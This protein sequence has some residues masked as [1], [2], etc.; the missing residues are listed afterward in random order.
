[1]N[2]LPHVHTYGSALFRK[3]GNFISTSLNQCHVPLW[4]RN[5]EHVSVKTV[6]LEFLLTRFRS[7][8]YSSRKSSSS[9]KK[10]SRTKKVDPEQSKVMKNEKDAFFVVRKGDV[11]GVFKSFADCQTQVGSSICDPPVSVYK[12][13]SLTK[14][15][16]IYLSSY[17]LKN[18]CYTIRAADVKE[19]IFGALMPCPFQ[20]AASSKGETSHNDATKKRPQDMLQLEYGV[21]LG[22]LGSIAVADLARK[23]A[24]LDPHAGAQITSSGHALV[25]LLV[26]LWQQS[27]TLEFDG[28]SKGNPG[29]AG[30]GA[31]LKTNA[32]NV[33]CKLREGL[34]IATNNAA[35]YRALILG[36]KHALRK[37]YTNIH[38]RGDSKLVCMQL[39]GLWKVKHEHMSELCEQAMKLKDKFL[40]FQINHVLRE[41]NG[42]ADAE[43]NLAVKLAGEKVKSRRSWPKSLIVL[44]EVFWFVMEYIYKTRMRSRIL[45]L[46][47]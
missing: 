25:P 24:K 46:F 40:S 10:T 15:T 12:G 31:V 6:D 9:T 23:H 17:G 16:E 30:A 27:C 35:E 20:E 5:F 32:G 41:L 22:S 11:V 36:L 1:M 28:A 8:C 47:G 14:E 44:A 21:G 26:S 33:I 37:G 3:A 4:K 19:D 29:P 2:C 42:E 45:S 18:A 39:Q 7:Q 43:A 13:Y 34:G 38:V